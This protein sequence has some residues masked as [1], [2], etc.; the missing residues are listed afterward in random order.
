MWS[1]LSAKPAAGFTKIIIGFSMMIMAVLLFLT[2]WVYRFYGEEM[3]K[4]IYSAN[5]EQLRQTSVMV[6]FLSEYAQSVLMSVKMNPSIYYLG[7]NSGVQDLRLREA[8]NQL[9]TIRLTSPEVY[10]IY[11]YNVEQQV[12]YTSGSNEQ[13]MIHDADSFYDQEFIELAA[14]LD[15][16]Q[17]YYTPYPHSVPVWNPNNENYTLDI[18]TYLYFDRYYSG[19]INNVVAVNFSSSWINKSI[20]YFNNPTEMSNYINIVDN[21]G[22]LV[23]SQNSEEV[24]PEEEQEYIQKVLNSSDKDGYFLQEING[25]MKLISYVVP[26]TWGYDTWRF[27]SIADY[28][29]VFINQISAQR[30]LTIVSVAAIFFVLAL[31]FIMSHRLRRP[32]QQLFSKIE[33]FEK[34]D[35]LHFRHN[36]IHFLSQLL[37][38]H[39]AKETVNEDLERYHF[40]FDPQTSLRVIAIQKK[41]TSDQL[42]G[43]E[44]KE[45]FEKEWKSYSTRFETFSSSEE[46]LF[47][48]TESDDSRE[49][50]Q[51]LKELLEDIQAELYKHTENLQLCITISS[52]GHTYRD[53]PFLYREALKLQSCFFTL[54]YQ[55]IV[56]EEDNQN[57]WVKIMNRGGK[58]MEFQRRPLFP[59]GDCRMIGFNYWASHAGTNMWKEWRADIVSRDLARMKEAGTDIIRVFPLWSDFQ[60]LAMHRKCFGEEKAVYCAEE[61]LGHDFLTSCGILPEMM[62]RFGYLLDCAEKY[63]LRVIASLLTGWMSGRLHVPAAMEGRNVVTDPFCI[64]WECRFVRAFAAYF[65]DHPAIAAWELGN[66]CNCLAPAATQEEA[67]LW[68]NSI[69]N[70]IRQGDSSRPVISG[71]HSLTPDGVWTMQLQADATDCLTIHPYPVFTPYC[72]ND[73]STSIKPVMHLAA[74]N[75]FYQDIG[76]KPCFTEEIGTTDVRIG[77][78]ENAWF[79]RTNLYCALTHHAFPFLWW[80][81][82]YEEGLH[83]TPYSWSHGERAMGL[84]MPEE[85]KSKPSLKEYRKFKEISEKIPHLAPKKIHAHCIL[86]GQDTWASWFGTFLL[87]LQNGT[88]VTC[89]YSNQ[90]IP[91]AG[92][93]FLPGYEHLDAQIWEELMDRVF[94]GASLYISSEKTLGV[95][96]SNVFGFEYLLHWEEPQ[97]YS[98]TLEGETYR[99]RSCCSRQIKVNSA[100]V[101]L[102]DDDGKPVLLQSQYGKGTVYYSPLPVESSYVRESGL[103]YQPQGNL[104]RKIYSLVCAEATRERLV[105]CED[106]LLIFTEHWDSETDATV[107]GVNYSSGRI[108]CP[109]A[110]HT[111]YLWEP[112]HNPCITNGCASVGAGEICIYR[113]HKTTNS[114][115]SGQ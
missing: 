50:L 110:L 84:L 15:D 82:Y 105:R 12:I 53:L 51:Y 55:H 76:G 103:A 32:F 73:P 28:H 71:M 9:D 45:L 46:N 23:F 70:A 13:T 20:G 90:K 65:H 113:V 104:F 25:E 52:C 78:E 101:L 64:Y 67:W 92:F 98:I 10:S 91:D 36:R 85:D 21:E 79:I 66:E 26:E 77:E 86:S 49:H 114:A 35:K 48:I 5:R 54:G 56:T 17:P 61:P 60:P 111:G 3:E 97:E 96:Y 106:P 19:K 63:G 22:K 31:I 93:Y 29:S 38:G 81:A 8:L 42:S 7:S 27:V 24:T 40:S 108:D 102:E 87:A 80:C 115:V 16:T 14:S 58:I 89:Q 37:T 47:I 72:N 43:D 75:A 33:A 109:C 30:I 74:E 88:G 94:H 39:Y 99:A 6:E 4:Q 34:Q 44:W 41:K 112:V 2:S 18:Y 100:K 62:E 68:T 95:G 107:I 11:I 83:H 59:D 69:A 1:P 57:D